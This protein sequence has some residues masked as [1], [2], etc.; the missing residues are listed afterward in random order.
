MRSLYYVLL[1][2]KV[3]QK[4]AMKIHVQLRIIITLNMYTAIKVKK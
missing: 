2:I 1:Y 4:F 3:T